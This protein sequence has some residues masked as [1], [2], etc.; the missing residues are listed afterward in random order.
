MLIKLERDNIL[1]MIMTGNSLNIILGWNEQNVQTTLENLG[2]NY[3]AMRGNEVILTAH[4][5]V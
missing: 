1:A 3:F 2:G 5:C 4:T